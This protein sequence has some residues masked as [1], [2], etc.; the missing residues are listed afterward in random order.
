M[1]VK[2]AESEERERHFLMSVSHELRTPLTGIRGHVDALRDGL[3]DDPELQCVL[4]L[5]V[6][7]QCQQRQRLFNPD[8]SRKPLGAPGSRQQSNNR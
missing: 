7:A 5:D 1:A 2:L 4:R 6:C 3:V 8:Q